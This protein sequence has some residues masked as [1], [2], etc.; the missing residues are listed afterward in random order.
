MPLHFRDVNKASD[1][2][3]E[4]IIAE[5]WDDYR[6][7]GYSDLR[8]IQEGLNERTDALQDEGNAAWT[9]YEDHDG[10]RFLKARSYAIGKLM[11]WIEEKGT[12][13]KWKDLSENHREGIL[14]SRNTRTRIAS[15]I[16]KVLNRRG[17]EPTSTNELL[18]E[19]DDIRGL[20]ERTTYRYLHRELDDKP[21]SVDEWKD[22]ARERV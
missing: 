9:A 16:L 20:S 15:A 8:A 17:D 7:V 10:L 21:S 3:R 6:E 18:N 1:R 14:D 13:P 2:S 4:A 11:T 19:V 12:P 22:W 5:A